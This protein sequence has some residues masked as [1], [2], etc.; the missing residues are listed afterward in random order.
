MSINREALKSNLSIITREL[1]GYK[2]DFLRAEAT[3]TEINKQIV[4]QKEELAR[5][6]IRSREDLDKL[7]KDIEER[8]IVVENAIIKYR[9]GVK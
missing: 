9:E 8:Y 4:S 6:G 3:L 1:E 5:Q 2:N 7:W